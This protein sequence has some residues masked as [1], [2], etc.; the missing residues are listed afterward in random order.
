MEIW[1]CNSDGSNPVQ[2][3]TFRGSTADA[4][5]W[6]PNN[7]TIAFDS[8]SGGHSQIFLIKAEG[9]LPHP[10][11]EGSFESVNASWSRDAHWIYFASNRSGTWQVW[12]VRGEGGQPV[13]ITKEGGFSA[14]ESADG[15]IVYYRKSSEPEIWRVPAEG[16]PETVVSPLL[17]A[18][19]WSAWALV[20][21][22]IFFIG[23]ESASD[24]ILKFFDFAKS[25]VKN[26]A[27]LK[28]HT[29]WLS[30]SDDGKWILHDQPGQLESGIMM[31][32]NFR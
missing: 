14:F 20:D 29:S 5:R 25:S 16:G 17:R 28:K 3:T 27:V 9:G 15:K 21:N 30:A 6:S 11:T 24:S 10:I 4:P 13:Q 7:Q 19:P 23:D 1:M 32:E 26:I 2:L 12:K 22:G 8:A 31:L 18:Q